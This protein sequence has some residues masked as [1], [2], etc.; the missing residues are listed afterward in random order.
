VTH[1]GKTEERK[2]L[3][4]GGKNRLEGGEANER[5]GKQQKKKRYRGRGERG[6]SISLWKFSVWDPKRVHLLLAGE[7]QG[8]GTQWNK[9]RERQAE[10][11]KKLGLS[12]KVTNGSLPS[13][14]FLTKRSI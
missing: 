9:L 2:A 7:S 8:G 6:L 1:A 11:T 5:K 4:M 14:E 3:L 13:S 10:K 12:R